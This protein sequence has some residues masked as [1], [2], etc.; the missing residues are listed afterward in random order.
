LRMREFEKRERVAEKEKRLSVRLL[1]L[2]V[3]KQF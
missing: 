1:G 3:G 2:S